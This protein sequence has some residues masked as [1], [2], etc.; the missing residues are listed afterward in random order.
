MSA[1]NYIFVARM[2]DGSYRVKEVL[3]AYWNTKE[4]CIEEME[5]GTRFV[6]RARALVY[7]HDLANET[8]IE[9]GVQEMSLYEPVW[10][11]FE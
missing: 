2:P 1:D 9:Y 7:A 10:V 8:Y 5:R 3:G 11:E 6:D 4:E